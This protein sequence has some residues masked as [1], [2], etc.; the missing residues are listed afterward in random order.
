MTK[1]VDHM[2]CETIHVG[3]AKM[4]SKVDTVVV[5]PEAS[6]SERRCTLQQVFLKRFNLE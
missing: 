1:V 4:V 6:A 5:M 2:Q 3:I